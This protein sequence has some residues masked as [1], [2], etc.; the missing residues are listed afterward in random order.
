MNGL[1]KVMI[2]QYYEAGPDGSREGGVCDA[3]D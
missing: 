3:I 1:K 2:T